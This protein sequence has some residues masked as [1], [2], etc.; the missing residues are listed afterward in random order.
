MQSLV[1]RMWLLYLNSDIYF[2]LAE[3]NTI[4]TQRIKT[5][6]AHVAWLWDL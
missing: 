3:L 1:W 4:C 2:N 5:K 6:Q